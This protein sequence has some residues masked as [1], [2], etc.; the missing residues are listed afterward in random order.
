MDRKQHEKIQHGNLA[1][2]NKKQTAAMK[3]DK[4]SD[5]RVQTQQRVLR[6]LNTQ[7]SIRAEKMKLLSRAEEGLVQES[8]NPYST[9]TFA[10][11]DGNEI[12]ETFLP[13]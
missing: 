7:L 12:T 1:T 4:L 2:T 8:F 11:S 9:S 10:V 6:D 3:V 13:Q 5:E